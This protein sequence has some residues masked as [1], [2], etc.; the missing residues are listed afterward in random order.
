M[1]RGSHGTVGTGGRGV[2]LVP[3]G[4][5]LPVEGEFASESVAG[6]FV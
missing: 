5:F 2:V 3:T 6:R 4:I 1:Q